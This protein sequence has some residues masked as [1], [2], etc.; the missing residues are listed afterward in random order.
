V[1]NELEVIHH[2]MEKKRASLSDK[3]DALENQVL[4]IVHETGDQ[5]SDIVQEVKSTVE[6]VVEDVKS[7]ANTVTEGVEKTV[8]SVKETLNVSEH[9]RRHPWL[10]VGGA[11]TAGVVSGY[12]SGGSEE[13]SSTAGAGWTEP[14]LS[15]MPPPEA[16]SPRFEQ[17]REQARYEEPAQEESA[18]NVLGEA[19]EK[20]L[21]MVKGFAIGSLMSVLGH[22]VNNALPAELRSDAS[23]ILHDL[24]TKLGGRIMDESQ[25]QS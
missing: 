1:D 5:V 10:A 13:R 25:Q 3:I 6:T 19:S 23:N 7:T 18:W 15:T 9:I 21:D 24:T 17:A 11:F 14:S 4:N 22:V 16:P 12:L 8:E 20:A 2:E